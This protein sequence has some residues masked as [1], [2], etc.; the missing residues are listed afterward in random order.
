MPKNKKTNQ[1]KTKKSPN[2]KGVS[3]SGLTTRQTNAMKKHSQHH[4]V[5]HLKQMVKEMK[6]GKTFSASHKLAMKKV[7]K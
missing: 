1:S 6:K 7:G 5:K 2:L 3:V 4:T